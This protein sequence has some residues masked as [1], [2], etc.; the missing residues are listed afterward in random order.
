MDCTK[1]LEK[2]RAHGFSAVY[3][4]TAQQAAEYLS[5]E[6]KGE[7][8]G[9]GGSQTCEEMGLYDLLA[10]ENKVYWHWKNPADKEHYPEFTTYLCSANAVAET[11]EL[12][13]IDGTGNRL[14]ATLY[15]PKQMFFICGVNKIV[16]DL[17]AAIDRAY[18]V[19]TPP[20]AARLKRKTPCATQG[21]CF[22][23]DSPQRLCRAMVIYMRPM[24]ASVRTEVVLVGETLGY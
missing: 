14:A 6:I 16:P 2:L 20:N 13:N 3:F 24:N 19:A 8:V 23:C 7:T 17:A 12:V 11:G 9:F 1:L 10:K 4:D 15:G 18:N 5:R 21:R 22:D